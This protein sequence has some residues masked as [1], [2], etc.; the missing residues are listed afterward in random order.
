MVQLLPIKKKTGFY[1]IIYYY[2]AVFQIVIERVDS[3]YW[4]SDTECCGHT[5]ASHHM[6]ETVWKHQVVHASERCRCAEHSL[7][8]HMTGEFLLKHKVQLRYQLTP[9]IALTPFPSKPGLPYHACL[10]PSW[11]CHYPAPCSN[12][13]YGGLSAPNFMFSSCNIAYGT[14][15]WAL[16]SFTHL[17]CDL[18][19][20]LLE[21]TFLQ[22][23]FSHL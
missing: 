20:C 11:H 1:E 15:A 12:G 6:H 19:L 9:E 3:V 8:P 22:I 10:L 13:V 5:W 17:L 21:F 4:Y 2:E 18:A 23:L 16:G 14:R 7:Q